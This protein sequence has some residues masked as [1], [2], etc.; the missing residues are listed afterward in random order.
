V[1]HCRLIGG[2]S[3]LL[4]PQLFSGV[5]PIVSGVPDFSLTVIIPKIL[6]FICLEDKIFVVDAT[7]IRTRAASFAGF[8]RFRSVIR[9][10]GD[11]GNPVVAPLSTSLAGSG[12]SRKTLTQA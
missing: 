12:Q 6:D 2:S 1:L 7:K 3:Y 4:K 11:T 8:Y 10:R 5:P 9:S